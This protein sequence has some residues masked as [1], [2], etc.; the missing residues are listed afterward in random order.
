MSKQVMWTDKLTEEFIK[1]AA[2]SDDEAYVMRSRARGYTVTQQS[3]HLNKSVA[4]VHRMI[5]TLK[6]K[7]DAVQK[8]YPNEFPPRKTSKVEEFMDEN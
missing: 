7:Y 3:L 2:L 5:A 6:K 1:R 4:T 8:E